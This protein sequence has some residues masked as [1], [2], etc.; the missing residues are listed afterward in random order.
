MDGRCDAV[1]PETLEERSASRSTGFRLHACRKP[2][3]EYRVNV[4]S[5]AR[6]CSWE[7][8]S[9]TFEVTSGNVD[10]IASYWTI[11]GKLNFV[12]GMDL[13]GSP[14]E[15][16]QRVKA[17]I[18][19]G[20]TGVG[21]T[22]PDLQKTVSRYGYDGISSILRDNGVKLFEVEFLTDWFTDG[23]RR[24]QSDLI[25]RK[26][27]SAAEKTGA[28]R[29]KIGGD[30]EGKSWPIDQV[31]RCFAE[32]CDQAKNAGTNVVL[33]ILPWSNIPDIKTGIEVVS[34]AD[35]S[36]GGL[37]VDIWHMAR[38][39]FLMMKSP[40]PRRFLGHVEL[41]MQRRRRSTAHRRYGESPTAL[42]RE[43]S[44]FGLPS[45]DKG[46]G[47]RRAIRDRNYFDEQRN[48]PLKEAV[49]RSFTTA[50]AQFAGIIP[51]CSAAA[52]HFRNNETCDSSFRALSRPLA[53]SRRPHAA[54]FLSLPRQDSQG[55]QRRHSDTG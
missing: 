12:D 55:R 19:G 5:A 40:L 34:S 8:S 16:L 20:Y 44:M 18:G 47:V 30:M 6:W 17:A 35:K 9:A 33:E 42:A 39:G 28:R 53:A 11:A 27:L 26:L 3:T 21:L 32:L 36:N 10:L 51:G 38:G 25:R 31:I 7:S 41:S 50:M 2:Y 54:A 45:I 48:R 15:F 43:V 29:I 46:D 22:Y 14:H 49:E 24:R 37:L 13:D 1:C 23:D 52:R 4:T